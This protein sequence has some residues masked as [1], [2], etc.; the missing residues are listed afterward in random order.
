MPR[1]SSSRE[2]WILNALQLIRNDENSTN[3]VDSRGK[4]EVVLRWRSEDSGRFKPSNYAFREVLDFWKSNNWEKWRN[5]CNFKCFNK[6]LIVDLEEFFN[7]RETYQSNGYMQTW[8]YMQLKDKLI[9]SFKNI[10]YYFSRSFLYKPFLKFQTHHFL[11][12]CLF[13]MLWAYQVLGRIR[14]FNLKRQTRETGN[15][16]EL[17]NLFIAGRELNLDCAWDD[18]L[19]ASQESSTAS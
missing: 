15:A 18:L 14:K 2:I 19:D 9:C 16:K 7:Y 5:D 6:F 17:G 12:T 4:H 13:S 10:L 3:L 1:W 8:C 11:T